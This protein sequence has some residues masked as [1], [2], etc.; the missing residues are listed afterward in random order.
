[1]KLF[2]LIVEMLVGIILVGSVLL[3]AAPGEG[4]GSIGGR[5]HMFKGARTMQS[6][7]TRF[8]AVVGAIFIGLALLLA[9]LH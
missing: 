2:L 5:A 4:L 9:L 3:H 1:M 6:G 8:T 7:L